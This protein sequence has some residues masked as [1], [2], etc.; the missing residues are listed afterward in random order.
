MRLSVYGRMLL[1]SGVKLV[2]PGGI[3]T[4]V[5]AGEAMTF[6]MKKKRQENTS[7]RGDYRLEVKSGTFCYR[8]NI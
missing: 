1:S 7:D 2:V 8:E 3:F 5:G 6:I 4:L